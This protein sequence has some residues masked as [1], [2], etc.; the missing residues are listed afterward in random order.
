M[1]RATESFESS[2]AGARAAAEAALRVFRDGRLKPDSVEIEFG[3]KITA[4]SGAV[5]VKG[6]AEGHLVV[7]LAWT[8]QGRPAAAGVRQGAPADSEGDDGPGADAGTEAGPGLRAGADSGPGSGAEHR[9]RDG[10]GSG[11]GSG[12]EGGGA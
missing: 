12:A 9:D 2:L 11:P 8:P 6:S 7:K 4:E 5:L 3:V 1:R 10:A